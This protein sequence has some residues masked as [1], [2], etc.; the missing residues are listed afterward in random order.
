MSSEVSDGF[1][2]FLCSP[3]IEG[4]WAGRL[5]HLSGLDV[6]G[7]TAGSLSRIIQD[8]ETELWE[9][10]RIVAE[11]SPEEVCMVLGCIQHTQTLIN[12]L[13]FVGRTFSRPSFIPYYQYSI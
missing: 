3:L 7:S 11:A 12:V 9:S 5:L 2:W 10:K 8:R 1:I 4:A 6:I 13:D